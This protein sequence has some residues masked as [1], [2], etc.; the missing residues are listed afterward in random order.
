MRSDW[1]QNQ[2]LPALFSA[3]FDSFS[4]VLDSDESILEFAT[5]ICA[6]S[7]LIFCPS[8]ARPVDK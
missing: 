8:S 6:S 3:F 1:V 2:N 4:L 5:I 7:P